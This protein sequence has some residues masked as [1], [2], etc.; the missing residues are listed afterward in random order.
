VSLQDLAANCLVQHDQQQKNSSRLAN[1]MCS[2][3]LAAPIRVHP[4]MIRFVRLPVCP[5]PPPQVPVQCPPGTTYGRYFHLLLH[6]RGL[7]LLG[8]YRRVGQPG[9]AYRVVITNARHVSASLAAGC[10]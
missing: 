6:T 5:C 8:V 7:L 9:Q 10:H 1:V 4:R 2:G 3:F